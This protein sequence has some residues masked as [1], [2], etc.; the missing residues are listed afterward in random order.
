MTAI[1]S[2][3]QKLENLLNSATNERQRKMYQALLDKARKQALAPSSIS[4]T[5]LK[6]KSTTERVKPGSSTDKQK[7]SK[8]ADKKASPAN[9]NAN[10]NE[11]TSDVLKQDRD[12][13][14]APL[15]E[16]IA[17]PTQQPNSTSTQEFGSAQAS[18]CKSGVSLTRMFQ[19][20]GLIKCT[21]YIENDRLKLNL[22]DC[23]YDLK[24]VNGRWSKQFTQL[25][26]DL[27]SN[28]SRPIQLRVYPNI[29]HHSD[30]LE[31]PY[32]HSFSLVRAYFDESK[33]LDSSESF[34]FRGIF[35]YVPY[36]STP[37][38]SIHRNIDTL[39]LYQRLSNAAKK[40]F[41]RPQA[42]P[43]VWSAPVEP[44]VY[45]PKLEKSKQMPRYFVEVR[46][47][48]DDGRYTVVEMLNEP[49]LE[50][51]KFITPIK[52]PQPQPS[53]SDSKSA[54]GNDG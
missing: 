48:F 1:K 15:K 16:D 23:D 6:A 19:A 25:K 5:P 7:Q 44:F 3:L 38:I 28:G 33:C 50:I 14:K 35:T 36:C 45:D 53:D 20:V 24:K 27:E 12:L 42:F 47:T 10:E 9:N 2:D 39:K 4:D 26:Q 43:V 22:D 30:N 8:L 49:T 46:A 54:Y 32:H 18:P 29:I 40:S 34:I 11:V 37:V 52:N 13:S 41:I 17:H 51:P 31:N 21:P